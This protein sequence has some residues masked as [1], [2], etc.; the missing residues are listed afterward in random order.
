MAKCNEVKMS[1]GDSWHLSYILL[2]AQQSPR[3]WFTLSAN[4]AKEYNL[5]SADEDIKEE[6]QFKK[7]IT[8]FCSQTIAYQIILYPYFL[9]IKQYIKLKINI[10]KNQWRREVLYFIA[11]LKKKCYHISLYQLICLTNSV[12]VDMKREAQD[13]YVL[14]TRCLR[15]ITSPL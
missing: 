12:V 13:L 14:L 15:H 11:L 5:N 4:E 8:V 9:K 6:S 10:C 3:L 2:G 1:I 7:L